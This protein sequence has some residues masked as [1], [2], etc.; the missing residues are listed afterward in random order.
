MLCTLVTL[1]RLLLLTNNK[2]W[3]NKKNVLFLPTLDIRNPIMKK[4]H[5]SLC[6]KDIAKVLSE[7]LNSQN[8]ICF[9]N[10]SNCLFMSG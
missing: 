6:N 8:E 4:E 10:K 2:L 5:Y 7:Q 1:G 3:Q 9:S